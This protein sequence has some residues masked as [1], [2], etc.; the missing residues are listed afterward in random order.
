MTENAL[1]PTD[2]RGN[3][4]PVLSYYTTKGTANTFASY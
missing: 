1:M 4:M 3:D 2:G